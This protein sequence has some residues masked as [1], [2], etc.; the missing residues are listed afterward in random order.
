MIA[1]EILRCASEAKGVTWKCQKR[2]L[3]WLHGASLLLG[4]VGQMLSEVD[5]P[6]TWFLCCHLI[7]L[8][9]RSIAKAVWRLS[10]VL[11]VNIGEGRMPSASVQSG[12][13]GNVSWKQTYYT[14]PLFFNWKKGNHLIHPKQ[15]TQ[16]SWSQGMERCCLSQRTLKR[17]VWPGSPLSKK[18]S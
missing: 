9:L 16:W 18:L 6:T 4:A 14:P 13:G 8:I 10:S 17:Q 11:D 7:A 15:K 1:T 5:G 12:G 2:T 3:V